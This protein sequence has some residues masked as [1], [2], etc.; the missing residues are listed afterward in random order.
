MADREQLKSRGLVGF[1]R[2]VGAHGLRGAL[3]VRPDN[4]DSEMEGIQRVFVESAG[5]PVERRVRSC[6]RAGHGSLKLQLEGIQSIEQAEVLRGAQL[7]LAVSDLPA[8]AEGEFYY[9]QVI[10]L[11]VETVEGR[12]LGNID[13][14]F[15]NGAHDVWV[16]KG[17][18]GEILIPVIDDVVRKIDLEQGRVV[19]D[20]IP[21]LLD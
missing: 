4:P 1:G 16:V 21:G 20:P 11:P 10:G 2:I 6:A 13:E 19:I 15:F 18:G 5:A 8:A 3:R 14:V 12:W 7:Y 9:F 17:G